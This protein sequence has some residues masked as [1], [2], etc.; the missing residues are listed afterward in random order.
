MLTQFSVS[1]TWSKMSDGS[2]TLWTFFFFIYSSIDSFTKGPNSN[3]EVKGLL[4]GMVA[5]NPVAYSQADC[6]WGG[7]RP[8]SWE[9]YWCR[10]RRWIWCWCWCWWQKLREDMKGLRQ[11]VWTWTNIYALFGNIWARRSVFLGSKTVFFFRQEVHFCM[12]YS[13]FYT[14]LNLKITVTVTLT[15]K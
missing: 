12:A 14:E 7:W 5:C 9:N 4:W 2:G 6:G 1:S 11:K 8:A 10:F 13:A 3:F 15:W